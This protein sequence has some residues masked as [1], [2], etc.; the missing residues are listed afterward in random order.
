[1][2]RKTGGAGDLFPRIHEDFK[3]KSS[4]P[5]CLRRGFFM[6]EDVIAASCALEHVSLLDLERD[7]EDIKKLLGRAIELAGDNFDILQMCVLDYVALNQI[8]DAKTTLQRLVNEEYN[9]GL[10]GLLLSRIYCKYDK[11]KKEYDI[12]KKRIGET[13]VM[14]W[15]ESDIDADREYIE[16]KKRDVVW[17][18]D[19]YLDDLISKYENVFV[20]KVFLEFV[21]KEKINPCEGISWFNNTDTVRLLIDWHSAI[22]SAKSIMC[23]RRKDE[24]S[25]DEP[26][27]TDGHFQTAVC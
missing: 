3:E 17:W 5:R 27:R 25:K 26:C 23:V 9:V 1:L 15:I 18:F 8:T 22:P 11:N 24:L 4:I 21:Q 13:N 12:L 16:Y 19:K 14:P 6:R 20:Q 10:N 2:G 7:T